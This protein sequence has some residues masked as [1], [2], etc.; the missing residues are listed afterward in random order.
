M[1]LGAGS[2]T[3]LSGL[4]LHRPENHAVFD[5]LHHFID[6]FDFDIVLCFIHCIEREC[7]CPDLDKRIIR[8]CSD[9]RGNHLGLALVWGLLYLPWKISSWW[10]WESCRKQRDVIRCSTAP[11]LMIVYDGWASVQYSG[12]LPEGVTA[13]GRRRR[14]WRRRGWRRGRWLRGRGRGRSSLRGGA[15]CWCTAPV[16]LLQLFNC[17]KR[18]K[19]AGCYCMWVTRFM[20]KFSVTELTVSSLQI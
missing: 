10:Q 1:N 9:C 16:L 8:H 2:K 4:T 3:H 7:V 20:P 6:S 11:F 14:R 13:G 17:D 19:D 5:S 18:Q 15:W 12:A